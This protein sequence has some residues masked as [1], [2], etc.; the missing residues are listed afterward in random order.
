MKLISLPTQFNWHFT[1]R[2]SN[3]TVTT[4]GNLL[5]I[6]ENIKKK[7]F[8]PQVNCVCKRNC[9]QKI[10]VSRQQKI[11][12]E[13]TKPSENWSSQ[14]KL[15]RSLVTSKSV[16][17]KLSPV[18]NLKKRVNA[19]EYFLIDESGSLT[20]VCVSFFVKVFQITR[21]RV[22]NA[23]S[24]AQK[25]PLAFELRG[26]F[27]R[28]RDISIDGKYLKE[29]IDK[30]VT[31]ESS[32]HTLDSNTK[33]L[34]PRLTLRRMYQLYQESCVSAERNMLSD[35]IFRKVFKN[36]FNL[37]FVNFAKPKCAECNPKPKELG[38]F[39]QSVAAFDQKE[40]E[41]KNIMTC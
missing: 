6:N 17:P 34:H 14:T 33:Y 10:D 35:R 18:I 37:N 29:F 20:T 5:V 4:H 26:R 12:D 40:Q 27:K 25:N 32:N 19:H 24:S 30:F 16:E 9:A 8:Q 23:V 38:R 41:K 21:K 1:E 2:G 22:I 39:V 28:K 7:V 13:F 11:F 3:E 31:Y 15:L 36:D